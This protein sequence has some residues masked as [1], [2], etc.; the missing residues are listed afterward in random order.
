MTLTIKS[1]LSKAPVFLFICCLSSFLLSSCSSKL[2]NIEANNRCKCIKRVSNE[3]DRKARKAE[4]AGR[5]SSWSNPSYVKGVLKAGSEDC[6]ALRRKSE[7]RGFVA[8]MT[9]EERTKYDQEVKEI[10]LR[11]CAKI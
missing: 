8:R 1:I 11:K 3:I 7:H 10:M 9:R 6:A 4:A 2:V 5:R